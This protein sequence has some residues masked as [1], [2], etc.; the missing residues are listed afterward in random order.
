MQLTFRSDLYSGKYGSCL[1]TRDDQKGAK[2]AFNHLNG[3]K[4]NNNVFLC[5][6]IE[7]FLTYFN[8][9]LMFYDLSN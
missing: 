2:V 3:S 8:E 5:E 4:L 7:L 1:D 6:L 9:K